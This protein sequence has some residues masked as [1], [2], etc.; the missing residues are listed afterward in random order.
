MLGSVDD[1]WNSLSGHIQPTIPGRARRLGTR[2]ANLATS[3]TA[4]PCRPPTVHHHPQSIAQNIAEIDFKLTVV[5][6]G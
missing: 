3:M 2:E 4:S 5:T 1:I 6:P